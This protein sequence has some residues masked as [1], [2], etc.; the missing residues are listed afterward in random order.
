MTFLCK[1]NASIVVFQFFSLL[2]F[3][4]WNIS[5]DKK[6]VLVLW[7]NYLLLC[8]PMAFNE[9]NKNYNE[10][11]LAIQELWNARTSRIVLFSSF[12]NF[13]VLIHITTSKKFTLI[14]EVLFL[15]ANYTNF[16]A[17]CFISCVR[18]NKVKLRLFC[19]RLYDYNTLF[20]LLINMKYWQ[21]W[22]N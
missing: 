6:S 7:H 20:I 14:Y 17:F 22:R 5:L 12:R 19:W 3:W 1:R 2:I 16:R 13:S 15:E 4:V 8:Y 9:K 10:L 11:Y 18:T 21:A